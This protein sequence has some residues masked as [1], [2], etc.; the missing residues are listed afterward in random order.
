MLK[1]K[2]GIVLIIILLC[3]LPVMAEPGDVNGDGTVNCDDVEMLALYILGQD[4]PGFI[5]ENADI[6]GDGIIDILDALMV[7]PLID[8]VD[9]PL[10]DVDHNCSITI[11]DALRIAQYYVGLDPSPFNIHKADVT[12]DGQITVIDA[13]QVARYYVDL[14]D[15]FC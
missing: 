15:Q 11:E 3:V 4:P 9:F 12:C 5:E 14:I 13:L 2:K 8:P 6:N 1:I 7:Y 10:G